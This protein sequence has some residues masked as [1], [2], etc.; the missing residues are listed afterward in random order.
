V[1]GVPAAGFLTVIQKMARP[2]F[3]PTTEQRVQVQTQLNE[4]ATER[5]VRAVSLVLRDI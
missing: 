2:T 3:E 5:V 1:L 4:V